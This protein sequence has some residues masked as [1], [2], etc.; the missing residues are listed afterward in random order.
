MYKKKIAAKK[1][2]ATQ[3][4]PDKSEDPLKWLQSQFVEVEVCSTET[5]TRDTEVVL[6]SKAKEEPANEEDDDD[7]HYDP[8]AESDD[9]SSE[10]DSDEE[11]NE[12]EE[13]ESNLILGLRP[14]RKRGSC[15]NVQND[16]EFDEELK[17]FKCKRCEKLFKVKASIVNHLRNI[18]TQDP[19]YGCEYCPYRARSGV[20][21]RVHYGRYHSTPL[22]RVRSNII[23]CSKNLK[24]NLKSVK[25]GK[26][27]TLTPKKSKSG[28]SSK[29]LKTKEKES[30]SVK[31]M[32]RK[33][34]KKQKGQKKEDIK[35]K[36]DPEPEEISE[37]EFEY[38]DETKTFTCKTC[39]KVFKSEH[40]VGL[41]SG[42]LCGENVNKSYKC[43]F[44][45]YTGRNAA[46]VRVHMGKKHGKWPK[47]DEN[48][49]WIY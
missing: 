38:D 4:N 44:C 42:V 14:K 49:V 19:R 30:P 11:K 36:N 3:K 16:M 6:S 23:A 25:I 35:I 33:T 27:N 26:S 17:K 39:E 12:P 10:D 7:D 41:H 43:Y 22:T 40:G 9:E 47:L 18:C 15:E 46:L 37:K 32:K 48:G 21:L 31:G 2:D 29:E 8:T 34:T 20:S 45:P 5:L 13:K 24:D 28:P 1:Q